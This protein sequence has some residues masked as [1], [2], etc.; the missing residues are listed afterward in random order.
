MLHDGFW[1]LRWAGISGGGT[2]KRTA[3]ICCSSTGCNGLPRRAAS[4][5]Q[6]TAQ[7]SST[8]DRPGAISRN[9]VVA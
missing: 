2:S 5:I 8:M 1:N 6:F 3:A 4:L 7:T 9:V